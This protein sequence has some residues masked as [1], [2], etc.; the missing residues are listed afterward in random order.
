MIIF[1]N[2]DNQEEEVQFNPLELNIDIIYEIKDTEINFWTLNLH[3]GKIANRII[4]KFKLSFKVY[5]EETSYNTNHEKL[6]KL[7]SFIMPYTPE[8]VDD[9][10]QK[11]AFETSIKNNKGLIVINANNYFE[12]LDEVAHVT[13]FNIERNKDFQYSF[14]DGGARIPG[15]EVTIEGNI[16]Q[17]LDETVNA[18]ETQ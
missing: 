15:Y 10:I 12:L 3:N 7:Y 1:K 18:V 11:N 14:E 4:K 2:N 8:G 6:N 9:T 17:N 16:L 5:S 13:S